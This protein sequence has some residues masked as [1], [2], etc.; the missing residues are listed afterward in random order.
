MRMKAVPRDCCVM[1]GMGVEERRA[2]AAGSARAMT[3]TRR[4]VFMVRVTSL[5]K[6]CSWRRAPPAQNATPVLKRLVVRMLPKM[7]VLRVST[8]LLVRRKR[9][10][11][12][13]TAL[14]T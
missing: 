5:L 9:E 6:N 3:V 13:S 10:Q 14:L 4:R 8:W 2:E 1:M 7:E 11:M 12:R